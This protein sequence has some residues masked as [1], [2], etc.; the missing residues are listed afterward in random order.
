MAQVTLLS[1]D[2]V[3]DSR[4][5]I[6]AN[7][8]ELYARVEGMITG[9]VANFS[10]LPAAA[11]NTGK[12]YLVDAS[13]GS[14]IL[15]TLKKAGVYKSD[16]ATWNYLGAA[17]ADQRSDTN[18]V[19]GGSGDT[20]KTL[21]F[22]VDG[23]ATG[24]GTT[25]T[26]SQTA[27]RSV[28]LGDIA[29]TVAVSADQT[30]GHIMVAD[31]TTMNSVI[32][33]GDATIASD[34]TV[35]VAAGGA[36]SVI[37]SAKVNEAAGIT[38]GDVVYITGATGGFPQVALAD[39]TDFAKGDVLAISAET[40]A[41][42]QTM[43]IVTNGLLENV[44]T[45]A[46][47]E[48]AILYLG[49][50]G[51]ITAT[52][53]TGINSVQ[54]LGHAVKIN[55][56]TGTILVELD[57]LTIINDHNGI[58][59]HQIV[60]QNAGTSASAAYTMVNDADH[61][62]SLSMIGSGYTAIAGLAE[63]LVIYNEGY[64]K[65]VSAVDGNL[66]FEWW[67][68]TTDSHNLSSTSKMD[69]SADGELSTLQQCVNHTA[70][71]TDDHALEIDCDAAGFGDVKALDI[72][73]ATGDIAAAEDEGIIL[74]NV[75]ESTST[76]GEVFGLEVLTTDFGA[77]NVYAL[78]TGVNVN[79]LSHDSGTFLNMT[80][81]L[82]IAVDVLAALS[83]G[84]AGNISTFVA[85][86]DTVTIGYTSKFDEMEFLL[87][88]P[89]SGA[90][91]APTFRFSS[92]VGTWTA[93]TPTD[94]TNG[95]RNTGSILW[96]QND[97]S[98][99]IAG[100]GSEFLVEITRTRNSLSTTPIMTTV[101]IAAA[102]VYSWDNQG[103]VTVNTIEPT[104]D[105][106]AGDN[107]AA[108]YTITEGLILTG[109]GST[110]DVTIKNDADASV[111]EIPTGTTNVDVAGSITSG[112]VSVPTISST[113]SLTNKTIDTSL[114]TIKLKTYSY[115]ANQTLTAAQCYGSK[116]RVTAACT[117]TLPAVAEGMSVTILTIGAI[118]VSVDSNASDLIFL[119]G[120]ALDDGDK[121]T[122]ASTAGDAAVLTYA[123]A[124]GWDASTNGWT[125]G[126][127]T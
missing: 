64:G 69:L 86:N 10:A 65:T 98:G 33:S 125:D 21:K 87:A 102:Q 99:W 41:D 49:V 28:D 112:G 83:S 12:Y 50:A 97:L 93:F 122:N 5:D 73:Y 116:I 100:T 109:Q 19:V 18:M 80:S 23:G 43:V 126:G 81:A 123:D 20:T 17:I 76:G 77:T 46:F 67:T 31:G 108:G 29:G 121:I 14:W 92:G 124:T 70:T 42:G 27:D 58:M 66:G 9:N 7:F 107:A 30:S 32:M 75:D 51:G 38:K 48:G 39:N 2:N 120:T 59:R 110:N 54:R 26:T 47:T 11:S 40:K 90:G 35:T 60:N 96:D 53:P 68:D 55:A 117:I 74:I 22:E 3:G 16:G 85:D 45:S 94:G 44:D 82:N 37:Q 95:F 103:I 6:N 25:L 106:T 104:G 89:A 72:A 115:S 127:A 8:T 4:T 71:A 84:G 15:F 88:T 111:I 34:G 119:D 113:E 1:S 56:S 78:K 63:A 62:G 52:H 13:E 118:A 114:N 24:T 57:G 79:P 36:D 105:T 61:R 101:Q 91:I